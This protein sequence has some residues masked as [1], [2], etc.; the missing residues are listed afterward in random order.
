M[1]NPNSVERAASHVHILFVDDDLLVLSTLAD[2][3]RNAGYEVS[4]AASGEEA[5]RLAAESR[6]EIALLDMRMSKMNGEELAIRLREQFEVP[7]LFLT[8]YGDEEAVALA[9]KA[10]ALGYLVKPLDVGQ[11][12]PAIEAARGQAVEAARRHRQSVRLAQALASSRET[13]AAVGLIME[14]KQLRMNEAFGLLRRMARSQRRKV[15][16]VARELLRAAE[17]LNALESTPGEQGEKHRA[18]GELGEA[19]DPS[20]GGVGQSAIDLS[21]QIQS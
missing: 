2:A 8:A 4:A 19:K 14:R 12:V 9:T 20:E 1:N 3:L 10:G 7:C 16:E 18:G 15:G 17:T 11:I 5:L 13:G 6:P 21:K